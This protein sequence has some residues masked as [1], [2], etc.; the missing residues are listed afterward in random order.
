MSRTIRGRVMIVHPDPGRLGGIETGIRKI[1]GRLSVDAESFVVGRRSEEARGLPQAARLLRDARRLAKRLDAGGVALVHANPSLDAKGLLRESLVLRTARRRGIKTLVFLHGWREPLEK[2]IDAFPGVFRAL[3]GDVDAF[4]VLGSAFE[5][6]LR[7]W[8]IRQPVYRGTMVVDDADL[9]GFD[10]EAA[11]AARAA[12]PRPTILFAGRVMREKG[13]FRLVE[14]VR[15]LHAGGHPVGLDVAGDGPDLDGARAAAAALPGGAVRFRGRV[16][17]K[18]M[19]AVYADATLLCL[20]TEAEG[21]PNVLVEAMAFGLPA[22]TCPVGAIGD[23][24]RSGEHGVL[25]DPAVS[26]EELAET[27]LGLLRDSGLREAMARSNHAL[28]TRRFLASA[29]AGEWERIYGEITA[30]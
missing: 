23:V 21:L 2:K 25:V 17:A 16:A 26:A 22:V 15:R 9:E 18:A 7:R 11:V 14:A 10:L 13:I 20:P 27:L 6:A 19:P 8:G 24:F 30:R 28:A 12:A 29:A 1:M 3:Y 5:S 4:M